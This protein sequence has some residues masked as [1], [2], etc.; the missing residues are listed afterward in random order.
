MNWPPR[1][2]FLF[3]PQIYTEWTVLCSDMT[4]ES[5]AH[6]SIWTVVRSFVRH[7]SNVLFVG[8]CVLKQHIKEVLYDV[9]YDGSNFELQML[10]CA[11]LN[12]HSTLDFLPDRKE[13]DVPKLKAYLAKVLLF[14]LYTVMGRLYFWVSK[15]I[16]SRLRV[17]FFAL[18]GNDWESFTW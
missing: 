9:L 16:L 14:T 3:R 10:K 1:L 7:S 8:Y 12:V 15:R 5:L 4:D 18:T 6:L 11:R 17:L 2:P 13:S